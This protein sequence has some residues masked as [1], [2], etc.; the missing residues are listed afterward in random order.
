MKNGL[1]YIVS[2]LQESFVRFDFE[3]SFIYM[4]EKLFL[5]SGQHAEEQLNINL[6]C[7][8]IVRQS[9]EFIRICGK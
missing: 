9:I 3:W 6:N 5:W 4:H 2:I 1:V 7:I 8:P